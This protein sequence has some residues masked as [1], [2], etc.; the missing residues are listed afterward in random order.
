MVT[1]GARNGFAFL[2]QIHGEKCWP[3]VDKLSPCED[4]CPIHQDVPSYV[5]AISRGMFKE[6]L[7]VVRDVNPFPSICGRVC[8]HPCE[9]AC[10][11]ALIDTPVAIQYLKRFAA[12]YEM[13]SGAAKP[14]RARKTKRSKVAIVG[15]GPTG[16]TA[17]YDLVKA[18]YGVSVYE[19]Q[20]VAG[21][22]L[23]TAI[24][25]FILP[26]E[27]V[28]REI[29]YIRALGVDI[30]T[31]VS[32]GKDVTL[33]DLS[34]SGYKAFLMATGAQR[35]AK[36]DIPG[37]DLKGIYYGL[38]LLQDL[39]LK[40]GATLGGKVVVIG[41]GNVAMDVA[42]AALR[43]GVKEVHLACL[44]S[45]PNMPAYSWEIEKAE[46]EGVKLHPALAPQRIRAR[47]MRHVAGVDFK[48]VASTQVDKEGRISW[49][50][51]EGPG[52]DYSMDADAVV[53]AI[54]Q[55]PDASYASEKKVKVTRRG[56]FEVDPETL[57]TNVP[58]VFAAGDSVVV[59]G[60]VSQ[61]IAA[62]HRAAAS[63]QLYLE[64]QGQRAKASSNSKELFKLEEDKPLPAFLVRKDRWSIP[65]LSSKDSVRTFS[66][67]MLGFNQ[68]MAV[69]EAKRCL[70]C[71]MC[72]N[73]IF[74]RAQ[75]CFATAARLL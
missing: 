39:K 29:D 8:H 27:V 70:N 54:G 30:R 64:R 51:M 62:G 59:A 15:S 47:D 20:P 17:A 58:G 10:N 53:I 66:E 40:K 60:S 34:R 4:A 6:A 41:G 37:S 49:T 56:A 13:N 43:L 32:V 16:L 11:R 52:S 28:Q 18:G 2:A 24:P 7:E 74:D 33:E 75:I 57:A 71:R 35:S 36:L 45:R 44:E 19:A 67:V 5:I 3:T 50:L 12:E 68:E 25:E 48:R 55:V 21:G 22:V 72:G 61:S 69:E 65:A 14:A 23:A 1:S 73:C 9:D 42:R 63:L 26:Q 38:D 46:S 31:G